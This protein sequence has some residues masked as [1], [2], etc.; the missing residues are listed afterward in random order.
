MIIKRFVGDGSNFIFTDAF[1]SGITDEVNSLEQHRINTEQTQGTLTSE[2]KV[3][4]QESRDTDFSED[5]QN[6]V[7]NSCMKNKRA[8]TYSM[9]KHPLTPAVYLD[10]IDDTVSYLPTSVSHDDGLKADSY[11]V[12]NDTSACNSGKNRTNYDGL[13]R[14][15][16]Q[17]TPNEYDCIHDYEN[18][19]A[20]YETP[21]YEAEQSGMQSLTRRPLPVPHFVHEPLTSRGA[22]KDISSPISVSRRRCIIFLPAVMLFMVMLCTLLV[23]YISPNFV[24]PTNDKNS[25]KLNIL[26]KIFFRHT[27]VF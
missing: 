1:F 16:K 10:L 7:P 13:N 11:E 25:R 9:K 22:I 5:Q 12:P 27:Q 6:C 23:I 24:N 3:F 26:K 17:E 2:L 4:N 15:A 21:D 19:H 8:T 18:I 20:G 14:R